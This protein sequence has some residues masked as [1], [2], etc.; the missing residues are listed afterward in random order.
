MK[1]VFAALLA[2][3]VVGTD[4]RAVSW[5]WHAPSTSDDP[6]VDKMLDFVRAHTDIVT[7]VIMHCGVLTCCRDGCG[8]CGLPKNAS[9]CAASKANGRCENNGGQGGTVF[10]PANF[11][12]ACARAIP[13]VKALGVRIEL[14]LGEDDSLSSARF[15]NG[16]TNETAAALLELA[17]RQPLVD[18]FNLDLETGGGNDTDVVQYAAF[19]RDV[20]AA[21]LRGA[22]YNDSAHAGAGTPPQQQQPQRRRQPRGLRFSTDVACLPAWQSTGHR[23]LN[24]DCRRLGS[25]ASGVALFNMAT[26]HGASYDSWYRAL[27]TALEAPLGVL[28]V[29]L[30]CYNSSTVNARLNTSW[31]LTAEAAEQRVCAAMNRSVEELAIF[32]L[33]APGCPGDAAGKVPDISVRWVAPLRRFMAGGGCDAPVPAPVVCPNAAWHPGGEGAACCESFSNRHTLPPPLNK[34]CNTACA[35]A[36]CEGQAGMQWVDGLNFSTHPFEC[37]PGAHA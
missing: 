13:V 18:G 34:S 30:A 23:L 33:G 15:L 21:L 25:D 1:L 3:C 17:R 19:L 7:T 5:W 26:Y 10:V 20:N 2:F 28:K 32:A 11:S 37:C 8:E 12:A 4:T 35:R 22:G 16:H 29:G 9:A 14:W 24:R 6:A 27:H 36:E 31:E